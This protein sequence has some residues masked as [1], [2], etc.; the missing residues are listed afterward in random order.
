MGKVGQVPTS[1]PA[2]TTL[3]F[4]KGCVPFWRGEGGE[5][6]CAEFRA[7]GKRSQRLAR[8]IE[9]GDSER[10][11]VAGLLG[12]NC[13][14]REYVSERCQNAPLPVNLHALLGIW[15]DKLSKIEVVHE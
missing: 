13:R 2:I 14:R 9:V 8:W 7:H 15:I 10:T 3:R 5:Y 1:K 11:Y 12:R 6:R 4:K